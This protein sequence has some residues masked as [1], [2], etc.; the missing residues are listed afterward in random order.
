MKGGDA[1]PFP[2]IAYVIPVIYGQLHI[3]LPRNALFVHLLFEHI[4]LA[5]IPLRTEFIHTHKHLRAH[6]EHHVR[7]ELVTEQPLLCHLFV[8]LRPPREEEDGVFPHHPPQEVISPLIQRV[9]VHLGEEII[10][11]RKAIQPMITI[12][13]HPVDVTDDCFRAGLFRRRVH[14]Q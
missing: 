1:E 10:P 6:E 13:D 11:L 12:G 7:R 8:P 9:I 5:V 14:I 4:I 3:I 2:H